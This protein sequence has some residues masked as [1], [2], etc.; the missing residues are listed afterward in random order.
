[1]FFLN[2][3]GNLNTTGGKNIRL[4]TASYI[5]VDKNKSKLNLDKT[6]NIDGEKRDFKCM[7]TG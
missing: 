1:M 4:N 6:V 7:K 5:K 2:T 3:Y